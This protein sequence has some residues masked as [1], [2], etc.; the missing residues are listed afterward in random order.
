[1]NEIHDKFGLF[2]N[3]FKSKITGMTDLQ[4]SV[5]DLKN[6]FEEFQTKQDQE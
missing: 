1:M 4:R 3:E 6:L 2:V 5:D